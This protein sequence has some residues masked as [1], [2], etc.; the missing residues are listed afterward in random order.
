MSLLPVR[1][2][3]ERRNMCCNEHLAHQAISVGEEI[4]IVAPKNNDWKFFEYC[5]ASD[6]LLASWFPRRG[7]AVQR[8]G[9]PDHDM[10]NDYEA[11][12]LT[13][14][15]EDRTKRRLQS[16]VWI[17]L[18]CTPW[19]QWQALNLQRGTTMTTANI[20]KERKTSLRL[21]KLLLEVVK[22][23]RSSGAADNL[24]HLAFEW[25]RGCLGWRLQ[26]VLE[27]QKLLTYCTEFEGCC[28][29]LVGQ[30]GALL[31]KPWKVI[32]TMPKIDEILGRRCEHDH[33]HGLTHELAA[34][35]FAY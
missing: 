2:P 1:L 13:D 7:V 21:L 12:K 31:K 29:R 35:I 17:A 16:F 6:S 3:D 28:Y 5:C 24:V 23:I 34:K 33:P 22:K 14:E 4:N 10:S 15:I 20:E 9:L 27:L 25:P 11:K 30:P 8:L 32:S 19:C 18:T 26:I